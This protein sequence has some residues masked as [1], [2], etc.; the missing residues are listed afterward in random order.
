MISCVL[1][2]MLTMTALAQGTIVNGNVVN[3]VSGESVA[4]VSVTVKG[5]TTGTFTDDKGSFKIAVDRL[6]ST[7]LIS[8]VGFALQEVTVSNGSQPVTIQFV[9][10]N[11]LGQE[12]VVSATKVATRILESP[13]SI[14][15]VNAAAI[16][17]APAV[18]YYDVVTN[19]KGVDV[20]TSSLTF[21]TPT[22]RG[23]AG[24]GNTRFT[25]LV[26]GMDNQAPGLNFSV[27]GVVGLTQ[28]DVDNLELLPGASSALYGPGGM[29][30]TLLIT[31]KNPFKYQGLSIEIKQGIMHVDESEHSVSP[32]Y[33]WSLRWAKKISDKLAFKI[34]SEYVQAKDWIGVDYRNYKGLA[35]SGNPSFGTRETDPNYNGINIYGDETHIDIRPFLLGIGA[36]APFLAPFVNTLVA[37]PVNVTRTGY[38]ERDVLNPN[39]INFKLGGALHYKLNS[40]TEAILEGYWGT[41]N[42][43]YTGSDRYSLKNLKLGQYKLEF[44]NKNWMLRAYTTQEDAGESFNA[45]ATMAFFNEA[46]KPSV[47]RDAANKPSPKA[48]DWLVQYSQ[49]YLAGKLA[50]QSDLAAHTAARAVADVGRPAAGTPEFTKLFNTVRTIPIYQNGGLFVDKTSLYNVEGQYN[51]TSAIN[52]AAEI[53]VG[54][55]YKR[56][57]LNS[58]GTLFAD[59]E[60]KIGINEYGGYLQVAK[61]LFDPLKITLSGR[62]DKNQYFKGRFTPRA[63]AVLKVAENNNLRF[64]Y[65]SAYRFPSTQQQWI[66]LQVGGGVRLVGGVPFFINKYNLTSKTYAYE[67]LQAGNP[68]EYVPKEFKPE[69]VT[70]FELGYKGLLFD[71]KLLVDAYGYFGHY[72]DFIYRRVLVQPSGSD[73][74]LSDTLNGTNISVPVNSTQKVKTLGYGISLDYNLARN[75]TL[76]FNYSSDEVKD[77]SNAVGFYSYFNAPK[78]RINVSLGNTGFGKNKKLGFNVVYKFQDAFFYEGDFASGQIPS[79]QILDAQFSFKFPKTKS[80]IKLGAN[81]LLNEYYV[82]AIG[83]S[84]VGG[85]YYVSFGYNLY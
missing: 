66:D 72:N 25:Q 8:S 43:V 35:V 32:Y 24:S 76:G 39:T 46:W 40:R 83:N 53:L 21:K 56:Y 2:G 62:Y 5:S 80:I 44:N 7:L 15:R 1:A 85:L 42:T 18:S 63:T 22:T 33:N 68:Q 52:N 73:I 50:G 6:P 11:S 79:T 77:E 78:N 19:L 75:F 3:S 47:S 70:S 49:A 48:T 27:G 69:T 84:R 4:A 59:R 17:N 82:N 65:Q 30:G 71:G 13:V 38:R 74:Q 60:G 55:N 10:N 31:S 12:V 14:E 9:P 36:Q 67:S 28:L 51:L 16:R 23:F 20:V 45:S 54:G 61:Q 64:S 26:D 37:N 41:G 29:N 34:T 57:V 58:E 81:N